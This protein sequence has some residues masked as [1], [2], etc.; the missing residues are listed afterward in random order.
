MKLSL[1]V[2]IAESFSDKE[3]VDMTFDEIV[4]LATSLGYD[5]V[6]MRASVG[7]IQTPTDVL[8]EMRGELH[9]LFSHSGSWW[10]HPAD[11]QPGAAARLSHAEEVEFEL[12]A[13]NRKKATLV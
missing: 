6:C 11:L 9:L 5:A 7:G 1:S 10:A 3:K 2:R 13:A 4:E 8:K 12:V